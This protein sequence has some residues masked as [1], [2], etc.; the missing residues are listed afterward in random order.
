MLVR[1][2]DGRPSTTDCINT[3]AVGTLRPARNEGMG[4]RRWSVCLFQAVTDARSTNS[5]TSLVGCNRTE[6]K[7]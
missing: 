5:A 1:R 2:P 3:P 6:F 4:A 7:L